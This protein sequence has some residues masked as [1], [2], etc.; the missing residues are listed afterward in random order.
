MDITGCIDELNGKI[1]F[2]PINVPAK[3]VIGF[4]FDF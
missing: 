2:R 1:G 4:S 3:K